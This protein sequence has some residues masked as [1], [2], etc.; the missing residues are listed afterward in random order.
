MNVLPTKE[1]SMELTDNKT[2]KKAAK[3][4]EKKHHRHHSHKK[5]AKNKIKSE[6]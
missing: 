1:N 5:S 6:T 2:E 3:N 4:D